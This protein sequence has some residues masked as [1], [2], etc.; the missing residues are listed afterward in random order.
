MSAK[1]IISKIFITIL[2]LVLLIVLCFAGLYIYSSVDSKKSLSVFPHDYTFYL[3]TDSAWDSVE[4]LLD[5]KAMDMVLSTPE[6]TNYRGIFMQL[7]ASDWRRNKIL[8]TIAS[9][10]IDAALY[11]DESGKFSFLACANL[12]GVSAVTRFLPMLSSAFEEKLNKKNIFSEEDYFIFDNNGTSYYIKPFKNLLLISDN[13]LVLKRAFEA[14]YSEYTKEQLSVLNK[15]NNDSI[16]LVV[17]TANLLG[18]TI[19]DK[20]IR[21]QLSKVISDESLSSITFKI[22]DDNIKLTAAIPFKQIEDDEFTM[23]T[24][25]NVNSTTPSI[26]SRFREN[27][28][29]YTILNAGTLE[30]L[31]NAFLPIVVNDSES[32]WKKCDGLSRSL[33]SLSIEDLLFSWSGKE[34]VVFGIEGKNDPVFAVQIKDEKK[35]QQVFEK[36]LN[37]MLIKDNSSLLL[38]G[39]RIPRLE[40]PNFLQNLLQLF[41]VSLP[42][43][44]YLIQD[45]FIYFSESA[46]NLSEIHKAESFAA[47][48]S[49]DENWNAVSKGLSS[50]STISLYYNL[51]RSIP[52]FL[53]S[54]ASV[55]NVL[56]LYSIGRADISIKNSELFFNLSAISKEIEKSNIIPGFPKELEGKVD[57]KLYLETN[58]P[59]AKSNVVYWVENKKNICSMEIPSTTITKKEMQDEVYICCTESE[60]NNEGKLWAVTTHGEVYLFNKKFEVEDGFPLLIGENISVEPTAGENCIYIATDNK[61]IYSVNSD[62]KIKSYDLDITGTIKSSPFYYEDKIGRKFIAVYDKSFFG[63]VYIICDFGDETVLSFNMPE[64]AFGAPVFI[65]AKG[66]DMPVAGLVSQNGNFYLFDLDSQSTKIL[67]FEGF[68]KNS[69]VTIKNNFYIVSTTGLVTRISENYDSLEVQIPKVSCNDAFLSVSN[70]NLFV[71]P[72]GNVIYGFDKNLELLYPFP[73]TGWG[74]PVFVDVN[75]D[76][77]SD[78][79]T[80]SIDN[81]LYAIKMR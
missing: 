26:L 46:E 43:P 13:L 53:R 81:K 25:L 30:E 47:K 55:S 31:K 21:G 77:N 37:S 2:V 80:L 38:D 34:I 60:Q 29:Y 64:I 10:S 19:E 66:K 15:K 16:Q 12:G 35:R 62:K 72:D 8:S 20:G 48:I 42:N 28:Q 74:I 50:N 67:H 56:S 22:T 6:F 33:F 27:V 14:D 7:R 58:N 69:P 51:E 61:H 49:D 52:F 3:H 24:V 40:L 18:N 54:K 79:F 4:P 65:E 59:K 45:G 70:D 71:C 63:K 1:K 78:C 5:L 39:V 68:Y 73:I 23:G 36:F 11:S 76:K 9:K 32:L 41:E 57:G 17:N 44:Y 75:G